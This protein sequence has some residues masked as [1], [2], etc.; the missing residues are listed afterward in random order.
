MKNKLAIFSEFVHQLYPHETDYLLSVQHFQ[1]SDNLKLLQLINYNSKNPG[2]LLP[3][4]K[5]ID[6]RTYSYLKN[7][8]SETLSKIDVDFF[9]DWLVSLERIVMSDSIT[10]DEEKAIIEKTLTIKSSHY[11]FLKFFEVVQQ[12]RDYLMVRNRTVYYS[13]VTEFLNKYHDFYSNSIE[14]NNKLNKVAEKIASGVSAKDKEFH[15]WKDFFFDVYSNEEY[16][17]YTRYRAVVRL[18]ILYYTSREFEG[19]RSVY[20]NLDQLFKTEVFYSKRI[21][22]NYYANRAMMHSK[23]NELDLAETYGYLSIKQKNSDFLFYIV[24]LC[25]VLLRKSHTKQALH[26]MVSSIPELKK[27]SSYYYRIGFVSFYIKTLVA[28]NQSEKAVDYGGN[29][30]EGY[31]K[32]ILEHRWHLFF[33]SYIQALIRSEKYS[34]ILSLNRR[35]KL[36]NKEKQ[37]LG[38][39]IYI[40]LIYW[41]TLLS[42]YMEGEINLEQFTNQ[43]LQSA[44]SLLDNQYKI[45]KIDELLEDIAVTIPDVIKE[46]R[47]RLK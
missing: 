15:H 35:F 12:Y 31:K 38:Q 46:I 33:S 14:I 45:R 13:I 5:T 40:P 39:A 41:Y 21:L 24:N 2:N 17:G 29:F 27:T 47:S 28:N 26:L 43:I 30:L 36:V 8:I 3:Y 20:E 16:D 37:F 25:G 18:T 22:A 7:W 42:E 32:E 9:Y 23:L 1:K 4:D 34:R 11:Y 6:K 44:K 19:L 10:P